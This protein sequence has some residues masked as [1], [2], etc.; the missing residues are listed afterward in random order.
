VF[1]SIEPRCLSTEFILNYFPS[2]K[3]NLVLIY[4]TAV[5]DENGEV[6]KV[7]IAGDSPGTMKFTK[8]RLADSGFIKTM[9][10][11]GRFL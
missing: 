5:G 6:N 4:L 10:L 8:Y 2:S 7:S 11:A 3:T 1:P 9:L